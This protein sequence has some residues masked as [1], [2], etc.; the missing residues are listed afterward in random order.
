M[1]P[2][3]WR[4]QID[5]EVLPFCGRGGLSFGVFLNQTFQLSSLH[6]PKY[7]VGDHVQV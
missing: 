7:K 3:V 5:V 1:S 2:P 6:L 4:K